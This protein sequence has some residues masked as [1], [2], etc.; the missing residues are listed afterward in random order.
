M[1]REASWTSVAAVA[2]SVLGMLSMLGGC[3]ATIT[4]PEASTLSDPAPVYLLDHGIHSCI[5][6]PVDDG[7]AVAFCFSQYGYAALENDTAVHG[8]IALMGAG[9]GTLGKREFELAHAE[10]PELGAR[11]LTE[12][13]FADERYYR[14][15]ACYPL[16]VERSARRRMLESLERRWQSRSQTV[17]RSVKRRFDFVKD[18]QRYSLAHTC[19][20]ETMDWLRSMG[21]EVSGACV[22]AEFALRTSAGTTVRTAAAGQVERP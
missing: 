5:V 1:R 19:N 21:C 13:F 17:V 2:L 8:P 20:H 16:L 22:T 14:L 4:P 6:F 9:P 12:A 15:D 18:E 10:D 3:G 7:R 11:A